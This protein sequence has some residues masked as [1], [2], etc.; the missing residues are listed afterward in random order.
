MIYEEIFYNLTSVDYTSHFIE[1]EKQLCVGQ[2][3]IKRD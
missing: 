1:L 2:R 3:R